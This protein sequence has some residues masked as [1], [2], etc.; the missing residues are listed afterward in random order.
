MAGGLEKSGVTVIKWLHEETG[1]DGNAL[2]LDSIHVNI[3]AV[4]L[5]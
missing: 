5:Y 2:H 4:I 3:L 1:N